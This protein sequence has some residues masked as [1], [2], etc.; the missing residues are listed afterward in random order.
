MKRINF[1]QNYFENI[2]N[3]HKA[4]HLGFI[5][6]DGCLSKS[7]NKLCIKI[8]K[9]DIEVLRNF[10]ECIEFEGNIWR[11]DTYRSDMR[12]IGLSSSK[13]K[14]DLIKLGVHPSKTF[15]L[16][17]PKFKDKSL[18][19]HFIR[20]YFDGDGCIR[21][22]EESRKNRIG[23]K[24]GDVRIISGSISFINDMNRFLNK[25]VGVNLNKPYGPKTYKYIGWSGYKDIELLY[26]Y[27][28]KDSNFFLTRKQQT[29]KEAYNISKTKNKYRKK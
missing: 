27:L 18:Y 20:G 28:Y 16:E 22:K 8:H 2:D 25:E 9:K 3:E 7:R 1:N 17:F 12:E 19:R 5:M 24:R 29:F 15:T 21:I 4:Y 13:M 10:S 11:S 14:E 6:A 26:E 23:H